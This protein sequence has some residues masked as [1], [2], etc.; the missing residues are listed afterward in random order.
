MF[1][2]ALHLTGQRNVRHRMIEEAESK[3]D[4]QN[5]GYCAIERVHRE[6]AILHRR[7]DG[8]LKRG[9][10]EV[11]EL[12]VYTRLECLHDGFPRAGAD[13]MI[14]P[15]PADGAKIRQYEAFE[16]PVAAKDLVEEKW[17]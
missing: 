14:L 1:L 16:A 3:L 11:V 8:L 10:I 9:V 13:L 6:G 15:Q 5:R 4:S 2:A 7:D 12:H 17:V